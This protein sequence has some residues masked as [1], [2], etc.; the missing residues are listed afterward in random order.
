MQ[1]NS[2]FSLNNN[3]KTNK[4]FITLIVFQPNTYIY[5]E[6][7]EGEKLEY[8]NQFKKGNIDF[9]QNISKHFFNISD[10]YL[11]ST[12][13]TDN[14]FIKQEIINIVEFKLLIYD[15]LYYNLIAYKIKPN[16]I[17]FLIDTTDYLENENPK[18]IDNSINLLRNEI[19]RLIN[20]IL[21][22][23]IFKWQK[24]NFYHQVV[25]NEEEERIIDFID[26]N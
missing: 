2:F 12:K 11:S 7:L 17:H 10:N 16:H 19:N 26:K 21:P 14:F 9:E 25:N 3:I 13:L 6:D 15:D 24:N 18:T 5:L 1:Y 20:I 4:Y 22:K 23:N 8:L